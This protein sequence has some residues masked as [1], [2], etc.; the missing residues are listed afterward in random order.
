MIE[1]YGHWV[2]HMLTLTLLDTKAGKTVARS[3]W[4]KGAVTE[5]EQEI[6]NTAAEKSVRYF[7]EC[8]NYE[9]Y[10]HK[11]RRAKTKDKCR[12][13]AIAA[14]EGQNGNKRRHAHLLLGNI[15]ANKLDGL[16]ETIG[17]V[18]SKAKWSMERM[19]LDTVYDSDGAA[20]YLA[21]EVGFIND[22][23]VNWE[24]SSIPRILIGN[25]A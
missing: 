23:A 15:P 17:R 2:T 11:T 14:L 4:N 18:W 16:E 9:L 21:K 6:S 22:N 12:I 7:I 10:G 25:R 13:I 24:I 8:L 5:Y 20:Y 3:G 19:K 1:R